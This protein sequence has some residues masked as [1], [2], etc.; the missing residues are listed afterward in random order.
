MITAPQQLARAL[1]RAAVTARQVVLIDDAL[2]TEA[3]LETGTD[4]LRAGRATEG[5]VLTLARVTSL[6]R[7]M[8]GVNFYVIGR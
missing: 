5:D 4:P 7:P 2:T 3:P 1:G 8:Q 6:E